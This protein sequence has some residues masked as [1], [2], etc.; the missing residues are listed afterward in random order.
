MASRKKYERTYGGGRSR[1]KKKKKTPSLCPLSE[2][3]SRG[4]LRKN[5]KVGVLELFWDS[6]PGASG[7][8]PGVGNKKLGVNLRQTSGER[9]QRKGDMPWEGQAL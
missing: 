3:E 8:S 1:S 4:T 2:G 7:K 6:Q 9:S 5:R